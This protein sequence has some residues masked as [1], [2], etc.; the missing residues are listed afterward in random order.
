MKGILVD[1]KTQKATQVDDGL[2][3]PVS[4]P[5]VQPEELD[6]AEAARKLR[7]IDTMKADIE[8]LKKTH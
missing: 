7:E 4:P 1:T 6:L 2:P 3:M 8:A 5:F